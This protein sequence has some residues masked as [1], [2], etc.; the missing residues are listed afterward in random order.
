[1]MTTVAKA[2]QRQ[3]V[4]RLLQ[5]V[6]LL[7]LA[8]GVLFFA[9]PRVGAIVEA[10]TPPVLPEVDSEATPQR[11]E[12]NW[13]LSDSQ[14]FHSITQGTTTIPVPLS[15]LL[16]LEAPQQSLLALPF[17]KSGRF[18]GNDYFLRLGFMKGEVNPN[19][20]LG[21]PVG[22][23]VTRSQNLPGISGVVDGAGFTCAACHTSPLTYGGVQ[24]IIDGGPAAIDLGLFTAALGAALGQTAVSGKLPVFN[25]RFDR[26]A[27]NVLGDAYSDYRRVQLQTEL[28]T[29]IATLAENPSAV[30]VVEGFAR[31]DALNRIGN[32]VFAIDNHRFE[33]YVPIN[34]PVNYPHI[35]T[36]PWFDWVQYDGS[37][38]GPLIRNAG[39]ALGV[40]ASVNTTA[41]DGDQRFASS[42]DITNLAW[43]EST[44]AGPPPYPARSFGGLSGPRWPDQFPP[45][46]EDLAAAGR[47]L[48]RQ[49][50]RRCHLPPLDSLDIWDYFSHIE[51]Y[52]GDS[53]RT[54]PTEVL[55]V[56]NVPL[57]EIG[58]DPA[59]SRVLAD[60]RVDTAGFA[61]GTPETRTPG[62]G[63]DTT[64]CTPAAAAYS[65]PGAPSP[66]TDG[67]STGYPRGA[68]V[69]RPL[70][71]G[72]NLLFALALGGLVQEVTDA[73]FDQNYVPNYMRERYHEGRPNCLRAGAGYKARP[74]NGVWATAPFLHNG[75]VPTVY[76]MLVPSDERPTLVQLGSTQF[77]AE[78]L[79]LVQDPA[80]EARARRSPEERYVEGYFILDTQLDGNR[81]TGHEFSDRWRPGR[82]RSEQPEG[83]IGPLLTDDN[84]MALIEFL[85][86]Q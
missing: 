3:R 69:N 85:K 70:R 19:N 67:E 62:M 32:Q 39:E 40:A 60:R 15:W 47:D 64:V 1:M 45:I 29:L 80:L 65:P 56:Q 22:V 2:I 6:L 10:L 61:G 58:T 33:N 78:R 28:D 23:T 54:S 68:L 38:M 63:L 44:L 49:R 66:A 46:D 35:W 8:A 83:V 17:A 57:S 14:R 41:P 21:L 11:L 55:K 52:D 42:V 4:K 25:G 51:W 30:D 79:G 71:D 43:I 12:Q 72:P 84:R 82:R 24:Y 37:I 36:S 16:A 75:S 76:D 50:C 7:G 26:F 53:L 74:L 77:D 59:Q 86:T 27:T 5:F 9:G 18:I 73:W 13:S 20:L 81:N 31:L 48:Y 34:A